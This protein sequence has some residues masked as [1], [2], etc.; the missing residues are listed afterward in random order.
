MFTFLPAPFLVQISGPFYL[1]SDS[2][3]PYARESGGYK[4]KRSIFAGR[5]NLRKVL[6]MAA[7]ASL[8]CNKKLKE[9]YDKLLTNHK[10]A[11]VALVAVMSKLL[12]FMHAV[13]KNNSFWNNNYVIP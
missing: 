5:S 3:A 6:Y 9:F 11:R 10:P 12:C 7:V 1:S 13:V 8:R 2:I 4:G